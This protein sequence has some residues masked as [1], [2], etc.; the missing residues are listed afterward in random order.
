MATHAARAHR[1]LIYRGCRGLEGAIVWAEKRRGEN[2][3]HDVSCLPAC[4]PNISCLSAAV[5]LL[6]GS[7]QAKRPRPDRRRPFAPSSPPGSLG[8]TDIHPLGSVVASCGA[9]GAVQHRLAS[10]VASL[11]LL[12]RRLVTAATPDAP[13]FR[14]RR[15]PAEACRRRCPAV[16]QALHAGNGWS[17]KGRP[18]PLHAGDQGIPHGGGLASTPQASQATR[19]AQ[20]DPSVWG[21]AG[22]A[23]KSSQLRSEDVPARQARATSHGLKPAPD[24]PS[25][26]SRCRPTKGPI[27]SPSR[28]LHSP[29]AH[30]PCLSEA[31]GNLGP[32]RRDRL[33][34]PH[35]SILHGRGRRGSMA[36]H[37][38]SSAQ[39]PM[40][41][42][43]DTCLLAVGPV[44]HALAMLP[45]TTMS[46]S[47]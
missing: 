40:L 26:A 41:G 33:C 11:R 44:T 13:L 25:R 5:A 20:R 30:L 2:T 17:V 35:T 1:P 18:H 14:Q 3:G 31:R 36:H 47:G 45:A 46:C 29:F 19:G 34:Q 21:F 4:P 23:P 8:G 27:P 43:S 42:P 12:A 10:P 15:S 16:A 9:V 6:A 37:P 39:G 7:M 22:A 38:G 32:A 28:L 24:A